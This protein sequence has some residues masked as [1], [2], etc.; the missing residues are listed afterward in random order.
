[1]KGPELLSKFIGASESAVRDI[2][3][4][5]RA[6]RPCLL[7]FD[8]FDSLAAKRGH[9]STCVLW[10]SNF[11]IVVCSPQNFVTAA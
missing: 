8:E 9:D 2:F 7:F 1:V 3:Q 10:F 6:A 4:K 5:A 11:I